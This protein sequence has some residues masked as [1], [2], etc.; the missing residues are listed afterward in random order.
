MLIA[1]ITLGL[2]VGLL[3]GGGLGRLL[4]IRFRSTPLLFAA[5]ILRYGTELALRQDVQVV[6]L[7]R[8][9]LFALA[10]GLLLVGLWRNRV[11]PGVPAIGVG[12][13]MNAAVVVAN[14][15]WMP[16]WGRSLAFVG[17]GPADLVP[18]FHRL[19]PPTPD[20]QFLLH[21]GFLGD[22]LP[23]PIPLFANVASVGDVLM[24]IGLGWL[25]LAT[26][27]RGVEGPSVP[28]AKRRGGQ[29]LLG[30]RTV[31][32]QRPVTSALSPA[33]VSP[34]TGL[35]TS[36]GSETSP[37]VLE[38]SGLLSGLPSTPLG[39]PSGTSLGIGLP[40]VGSEDPGPTS[41]QLMA[42]ALARVGEHPYVRLA[43]DARFSA[44]WIGQT[45]SLFGDR[46]NQ[47]ALAVLVFAATDSPLATALV[48]LTA[49]APNLILGPIAGPF[50]DRW[51]QRSVLVVSDLLRASLVLILPVAA[52][53][54]VWLVF[55]IVL[56]VTSVST[57]FRP[58]KQAVIPRLVRRDDLMAANSATWT[59]ETLADIAGY[60][61]AGFFVAF[62]GADL[63]LA[64]W[65]DAATYLV[66]AL[67]IVGM[68]IP[69]VARATAPIVGGLLGRF[70][71]DLAE[72]FHFLR[73]QPSLFQNTVVS[74]VA[75]TSAGALLALTVVYAK[76]VLDGTLIPYPANYT[77]IE[78]AI[79]V[80]NL[81]GGLAIGAIGGR[82]RKGWLIG[83]GMAAMGAAQLVMGLTGNVALAIGLA[84]ALGVANLV[85][86]IPSQTLFAEL[87]PMPLM[88]RVMAT[89]SSLVFG[90]MTL[91][92]AVA[93]VLAEIWPVGVVISGFGLLTALMGLTALLLPAIR[94]S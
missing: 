70:R 88:G 10:F 80:G 67:L 65:A 24:A 51:D 92:M 78:A 53:V 79:G 76:E 77:A 14:G 1:G 72:G 61:V 23:V 18:Q 32:L 93:G 86:V 20:T 26:M 17:L 90:G 63:P 56:L 15:G 33:G 3:A 21:L 40:P 66:S 87:T 9:P 43:L 49:A 54:N 39:D 4:Q 42:T 91:A 55:P 7:L 82:L 36:A 68:A 34:A 85:F 59:A 71:S 48:F 13:A 16:V 52:A 37:M 28:A 74:V 62:L 27:L 73:G 6:E 64:F 58:A 25:V 57:F 44:F 19:L 41:P 46:L 94:D 31:Q 11:L 45:V 35:S 22:I 8:L 47:V 2:V 84:A 83:L 5:V 75:Q 81:I 29:R 60:P 38:R 12:V 89:R 50:V 30:I 69:P